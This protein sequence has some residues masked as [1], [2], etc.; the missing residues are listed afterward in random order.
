LVNATFLEC[1]H[2]SVVTI[3]TLGYGDFRPQSYGRLVADIEVVLGI[4]LMGVFISRLVS[5]QQDRMMKRLVRGQLNAEI[6]DFREQ[7]GALL[8]LWR[9]TPPVLA[10]DQRSA[11]LYMARGLAPSIARYWRHESEVLEFN[12]VVPVRASGRLLGEMIE[13][14]ELVAVSAQGKARADLHRDD[15][16]AIRSVAESTLVVASALADR[17]SDGGVNHS[18]DRVHALVG[19]LRSQLHLHNS[20]SPT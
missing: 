3:A 15:F 14:V 17:I 4:V 1:V 13:L 12:D 2:F 6:Q 20:H 10:K 19:N 7:L 5:R 8:K 9:G 16:K 11:G 18:R